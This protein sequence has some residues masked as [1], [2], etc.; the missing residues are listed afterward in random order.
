MGDTSVP[1]LVS[2]NP[3]GAEID[4]Q[5]EGGDYASNPEVML[6]PFSSDIIVLDIIRRKKCVPHKPKPV[7]A[8][9]ADVGTMVSNLR[10]PL[11]EYLDCV[12]QT[13]TEKLVD[14][15]FC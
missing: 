11:S 6:D 7:M 4:F 14:D 12:D 1:S 10:L 13:I 8:G 2:L 9:I 15:Q 5:P 3:S